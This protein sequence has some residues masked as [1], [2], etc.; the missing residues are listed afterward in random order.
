VY[1]VDQAT[2]P[3][4]HKVGILMYAIPKPCINLL[5]VLIIAQ[6]IT[7]PALAISLN[8]ASVQV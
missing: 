8:K 1:N 5:K 4:V 6:G 7:S 2:N 3:M